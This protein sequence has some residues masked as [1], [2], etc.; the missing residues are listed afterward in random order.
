MHPWGLRKDRPH[1]GGWVLSRGLGWIASS[2][3]KRPHGPLS[4]G[5]LLGTGGRSVG[6]RGA[7]AGT[8]DRHRPRPVHSTLVVVCRPPDDH[9]GPSLSVSSGTE[10]LCGARRRW[11]AQHLAHALALPPGQS[12]ACLACYWRRRVSHSRMM[13]H[14]PTS[15][16]SRGRWLEHPHRS[17]LRIVTQKHTRQ[18]LSQ[19]VTTTSISPSRHL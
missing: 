19:M 4:E 8:G 14:V 10:T 6:S 18:V 11:S 7:V 17:L 15:T 5:P 2:R 1:P 16:R 9:F 13:R 12:T 3:G